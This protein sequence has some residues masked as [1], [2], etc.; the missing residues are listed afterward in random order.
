MKMLQSAI[1][2][3]T[4][5]KSIALSMVL[6]FVF[7]RCEDG[8][9]E[10]PKEKEIELAAISGGLKAFIGDGNASMKNVS[11]YFAEQYNLDFDAEV[12]K[13]KPMLVVGNKPLAARTAEIDLHNFQEIL[14]NNGITQ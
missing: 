12:Q 13:I 11:V 6:L 3:A 8:Y 4:V 10:K 14:H 2:S 5:L 9:V 7:T 1:Q